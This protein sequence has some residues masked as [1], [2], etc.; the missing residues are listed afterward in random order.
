MSDFEI[1][2]VWS[3]VVVIFF[4]GFVS[5]FIDILLE[6]LFCFKSYL[7]SFLIWNIRNF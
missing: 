6:N 5:M 1:N 3:F 4:V 7:V 2:G